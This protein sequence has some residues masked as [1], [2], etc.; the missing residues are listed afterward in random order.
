MPPGAFASTRAFS[1]ELFGIALG[2]G[3]LEFRV[4]RLCFLLNP[5]RAALRAADWS[6][7]SGLLVHTDN[8]QGKQSVSQL[9]SVSADAQG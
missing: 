3:M 4:C 7:G 9:I 6:L 5:N 2:L 1:L 8:D